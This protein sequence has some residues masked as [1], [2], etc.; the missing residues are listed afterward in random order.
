MSDGCAAMQSFD[1]P[2]IA[3]IRVKPSRAEQPEPGA[4]LLHGFAGS[5]KYEQRVRCNRLPEIEAMLRS[6]PDAPARIESASAGSFATTS[7]W[8]AT[9]VFVASAPSMIDEA[10]LS[11]FV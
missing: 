3:C 7:G 11:I 10:P 1:V 4:R 2:T 9:S 5:R 6:W 8:Y